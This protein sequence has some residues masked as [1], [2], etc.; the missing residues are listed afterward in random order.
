MSNAD[1]LALPAKPVVRLVFKAV[2][3][4]AL[5]AM[6]PSAAAKS[7]AKAYL[8]CLVCYKWL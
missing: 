2:T 5:A 8:E 1:W 4:L 3:L 7:E 6:S